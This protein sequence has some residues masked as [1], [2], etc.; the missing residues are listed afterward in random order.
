MMNDPKWG[1][2]FGGAPGS[3]S[4]DPTAPDAARRASDAA[5]QP[6]PA[7]D[8][9]SD[10]ASANGEPMV[11]PR[12]DRDP[13][14]VA[15]AE[16]QAGENAAETPAAA[17]DE[18]EAILEKAAKADE[19]LA[20]AQRKQAEFE[21]YRKRASRES[22]AAQERG[23]VKLALALLPAVDNLERALEHAP[24]EADE[25]GFVAGVRHV[26]SDLVAALAKSGIEWFSPEG[27]PFDPAFHEA[28]AQAPIEGQEPGTVVEVF[29]RGYRVGET[30]VRPAR[31]VVAG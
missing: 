28:V 14:A 1:P 29:Q 4:A 23:A 22:A 26:H 17:A 12:D 31:V 18:L 25:H 10:H 20:L 11:T 3:G 9:Q 21:N 30:V 19:Y 16:Q 2:P 5:G 13:S 7:P 27:E 24:E 8:Q 15:E 6:G